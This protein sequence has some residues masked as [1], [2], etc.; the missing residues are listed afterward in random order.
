MPKGIEIAHQVFNLLVRKLGIW[1][2]R[3]RVHEKSAELSLRHSGLRSDLPERGH[4]VGAAAA[5]F[6]DVAMGAD[7]PGDLQAAR[8]VTLL[9]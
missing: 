8:R 3:M 9:G 2:A 4:G 6:H 1:H 5:L 7:L